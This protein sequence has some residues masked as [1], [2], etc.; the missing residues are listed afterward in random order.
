MNLILGSAEWAKNEI[1]KTS[2]LISVDLSQPFIQVISAHLRQFGNIDILVN[3]F[4]AV[5]QR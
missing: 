4:A 5:D 2:V 3:N 1:S